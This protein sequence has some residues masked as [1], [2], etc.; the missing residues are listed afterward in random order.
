MKQKK[1]QIANRAQK[2][3]AAV[4]SMGLLIGSSGKILLRNG[5]LLI[6]NSHGAHCCCADCCCERMY[7][8]SPF[9]AV[10]TMGCLVTDPCFHDTVEIDMPGGSGYWEGTV[11]EWYCVNPQ[12]QLPIRVELSCGPF[13]EIDPRPPT[14][15][16]NHPF[17][18]K[19]WLRLSNAE[20]EGEWVAVDDQPPGQADCVGDTFY[21]RWGGL[22]AGFVNG[23]TL[24]PGS[25]QSIEVYYP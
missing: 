6:A 7:N 14:P 22:A 11:D 25:V 12:S 13:P 3:A 21:S 10:L 20:E 19:F 2:T 18:T 8:V 5:K 9:R 15:Q 4:D 17:G 24:S 16:C 23:C 1:P